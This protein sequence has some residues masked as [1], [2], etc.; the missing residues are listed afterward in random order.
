MEQLAEQVNLS[1]RQF[2]RI[3]AAETGQSPAGA[4]DADGL[5]AAWRP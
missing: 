4:I 5:F 2:I 3:F 1:P